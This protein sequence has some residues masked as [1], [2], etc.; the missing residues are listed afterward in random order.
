MV[1]LSAKMPATE[2]DRQR[3]RGSRRVVRRWWKSRTGAR[4]ALEAAGRHGHVLEFLECSLGSECP[5]CG[6]M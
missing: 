4:K 1:M 2:I 6:T 3:D 5:E